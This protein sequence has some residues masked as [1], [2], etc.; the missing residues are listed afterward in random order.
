MGVDGEMGGPGKSVYLLRSGD[1]AE[2]PVPAGD[3]DGDGAC[4][5]E[6]TRRLL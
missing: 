2:V 4:R 1:P 3:G 5:D 6:Q